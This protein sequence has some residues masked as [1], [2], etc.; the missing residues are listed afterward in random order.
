MEKHDIEK[1]RRA[2][3][4]ESRRGYEKREVEQYLSSIAEWLESGAQDEA[5]SYAVQRKLERAGDTTGRILA[6]AEAEA[7]RLIGEAEEEARQ[8]RANAAATARETAEAA[9]ARARRTVEEGEQ[10]R[11]AIETIIKDLVAKRDNVLAE[12]D[13]LGT[14]LAASA[15]QHRPPAGADPFRTPAVLDPVERSKSEPRP[16][17]AKAAARPPAG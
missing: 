17:R 10:R 5:G 13:R 1:I 7:Q 6:T 14:G 8:T 2:R 4:A 11:A 3:F 9:R 12:I 16:K 15:A